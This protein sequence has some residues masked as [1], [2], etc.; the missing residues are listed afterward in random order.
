MGH[1]IYL[2][3]KELQLFKETGAAVSHCPNSNFTIISGVLEVRR[4]LDRGLPN[5]LSSSL[6]L[7]LLSFLLSFMQC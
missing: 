4:L 2:S 1:G 3:D 5:H 6:P 7:P